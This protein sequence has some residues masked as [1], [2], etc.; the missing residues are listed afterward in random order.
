MSYI[1][2]EKI[3]RNSYVPTRLKFYNKHDKG[4]LDTQQ[5]TYNEIISN[6]DKYFEKTIIT[7]FDLIHHYCRGDKLTHGRKYYETLFKKN[8][9]FEFNNRLHKDVYLSS[10][11]RCERKDVYFQKDLQKEQFNRTFV[12]EELK[13]RVSFVLDAKTKKMY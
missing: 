4:S 6:L 13:K 7:N 11:Q 8:V 1:N 9:D 3:L 10:A 12:K 5:E 2:D